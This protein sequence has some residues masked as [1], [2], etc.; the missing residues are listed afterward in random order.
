MP[1]RYWPKAWLAAVPLAALASILSCQSTTIIEEDPSNTAGV[2]YVHFRVADSAS[3]PDSLWYKSPLDSGTESFSVEGTGLMVRLIP[4]LN[5][6][7][8]K[9]S[10]AIHNYRMGLHLGTA[11]VKPVDYMELSGVR[12]VRSGADSLAVSLLRTFDSLRKAT[13]SSLKDTTAAGKCAAF[14]QAVAEW[15]FRGHPSAA[16]YKRLAPQGLDT[17]KVNRQ[18]LILAAKSGLTLGEVVKQWSLSLDYTGARR[19]VS[20]LVLDSSSLNPFQLEAA[21]RMDTLHLGEP[22][23]GLLGKIRGKKGIK[24]VEY[25]IAND[26][27]VRSDRFVLADAPDLKVNPEM[28][29]FAGQPTF[30]PRANAAL[31]TYTLRVHVADNLG[32]EQFYV[33]AFNV[34]AALD[35]VG[36]DLTVVDPLAPVVRDYADPDLV[37]KVKV[38]DPSGVKSVKIGG[39]EAD[40]GS[41]ENWSLKI[42]VPVDSVGREVKIEAW[43][44]A[45]NTTVKTILIRRNQKPIPTAPR[46]KLVGPANGTLIAFEDSVVRVVW[47]AETDFGKIDSVTID[48]VLA[49]PQNDT[50]V[51][52]LTLPANGKVSSFGVRAYS[53]VS[54]MATEYVSLG[55]KADSAGPVVKW[56]SP[57]QGHREAY[58]VKT[59]EVIV[60]SADPSGLDSVRI[61]GKKPDTVGGIWKANIGLSGPGELTRIHVKSW[62]RAHNVTDSVLLVSRDPIP[63]Q[64]PPQYRWVKPD[65]SSGTIIP[66][67]EASY[68][69]QCVLTDISG[70]DSSSV[71][72]NGVLA[73]RVNDS[74]WERKVDLP[75]DGKG[76]TITLEA[77]NKRG[78]SISGFVAVARA[79]DAEK[80]TFTR[81]T[82]T[83]DLSVLF[84][85]TSVEVGWTAKD[86]DLIAKAWIQD[87]LIAGDATGYHLRVALAVATQWIKFRAVDPAGNEVRDSVSIERRTDT[88]KSVNLSDTN[89]R[90]RSGTFWVKLG[91]ATAG[92]TIRYTLDGS[93]PIS[94]S[95]IYAD[96]I[97]IDTTITLKARGFAVGRVD[98]PVVTQG[99]QMAV[100]VEVY[101]GWNQSLVKLSDGSLWG[102]GQMFCNADDASTGCVSYSVAFPTPRKI[103]DSVMTAT[104][105]LES[106]LWI[107][108]DKVL[109]GVG[110]NVDGEM[111]FGSINR[112]A[113]PTQLS[114]RGVKARA[115]GDI[116]GRQTMV[117]MEDGSLWGCGSLFGG[118]NYVFEK[119]S[120]SV[121][122][123][124]GGQRGLAYFLKK[125]GSF[126]IKGA[127]YSVSFSSDKFVK[128]FDSVKVIP[129][130]I[131]RTLIVAKNDNT[132]WAWGANDNYQMGVGVLPSVSGVI[133]VPDFDGQDVKGIAMGENHSFVLLKN[134][135]M[136]GMGSMVSGLILGGIQGFSYPKFI[137]KGI[138]SVSSGAY[139]ALL[140]DN[141]G[142]LRTYGT[143]TFGVLGRSIDAGNDSRVFF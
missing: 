23:V 58:D 92:A 100:P 18:I 16:A 48:G 81:W 70:I 119:V 19:L 80:P 122:D 66:F 123:M 67:A 98:G 28:L 91:C 94:T 43:D 136:Y 7:G 55:R 131:N 64:L 99:Y 2:H 65:K 134:G 50:W 27:G 63:G 127:N 105:G 89:G 93:E 3:I 112:L 110:T 115:F 142:I 33:T 97:K 20:A 35:H 129:E 56:V 31:G 1:T 46:L 113:R 9:D 10:M 61:D 59:L 22:P 124:G 51:G 69:A 106:E 47:K 25:V 14:Q 71:L 90:L 52:E 79:A 107:A 45:N 88:V 60:S 101:A 12:T 95:P 73:T 24:S 49:K 116:G 85:T 118:N 11:I 32:N 41:G 103:A 34:A 62:D 21:L 120:D 44:G 74:V 53:S 76:Q 40:Q 75:P 72:I 82:D 139:H 54:L 83:R 39:V 42:V 117:L 121:V 4:F 38:R 6:L 78:V 111:A 125:D 109:Y 57:S 13:P 133:R 141:S 17:A 77:K 126:W 130:R 29:D 137:G 15:V 84:D 30:V 143:N 36:P 138:R 8:D 87:S 104:S 114:R 68:L 140:L 86:N 37:V 132:V 102:F 5:Q 96:S 135:D 26:S 128:L 108:N